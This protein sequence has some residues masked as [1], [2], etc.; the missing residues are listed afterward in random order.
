MIRSRT[1]VSVGVLAATVMPSVRAVHGP[2]RAEQPPWYA[3]KTKLLVWR[4][5]KG[6]EHAIT[7]LAD[8]ARRRAHILAHMQHVMG[9]LPDDSREV[10]LDVQVM[11]EVETAKYIRKKLTFAVEKGDRVPAYLFLPLHARA[12]C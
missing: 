5:A 2:A 6:G 12:S 10:P 3:D 1:L 4:D 11:E 7:K 8:W 9:P